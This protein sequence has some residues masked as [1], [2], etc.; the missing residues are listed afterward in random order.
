MKHK[1][2]QVHE[3]QGLPKELK[4]LHISD[5]HCK[6][7]IKWSQDLVLNNL[8]NDIER[9]YSGESRPD[10][11]FVT[12]DISFSGKKAEFD[13]AQDF[14]DRL[15]EVTLVEKDH[16]FF[17]PG[18][19]D[20]ER[21][22]EEDAIVG[23][24]ASIKNLTELDRI[25]SNPKR[26]KTLYKRQKNYRDFV[27]ANRSKKIYTDDSSIHNIT[28]ELKSI[29]IKILLLDSAWLAHDD[30]DCR[31]LAVGLQQIKNCI[32][33]NHF[34]HLV[35]ALIHHPVSWLKEFEEVLIENTLIE[36]THIVFR[37]HVHQGDISSIEKNND[38]LVIFTAGAAYESRASVNSYSFGKLNL[39]TGK[40]EKFSHSY[41]GAT[42]SWNLSGTNS[43]NLALSPVLNSEEIYSLVTSIVTEYPNY[44]SC[45]IMNL[46]ADVPRKFQDEYVL[47]NKSA[48]L[49]HRNEEI[50]DFIDQLQWLTC[51]QY[52]W[53]ATDWEAQFK[54]IVLSL[55]MS[56]I[57]ITKLT[58]ELRALDQESGMLL[59]KLL[60]T[61]SNNAIN[62]LDDSIMDF[63]STREFDSAYNLIEKWEHGVDLKNGEKR[64]LKRKKLEVALTEKS[65]KNIQLN[66]C[67]LKAL[68]DLDREE[69]LLLS[70]A[71][72]Q[73]KMYPDAETTI[74]QAF[75]LGADI[76]QARH[77]ARAIAGQTGNRQLVEK[78]M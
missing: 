15:L 74:L 64:Y 38:R 70:H 45:I 28:I 43:W 78:V 5:F 60:N 55:E 73:I 42:N 54:R 77:L 65:N 29:K 59:N 13:I 22:E 51:F 8:L 48:N 37:G 26:L 39:L 33:N 66:I 3:A 9:K 27:N 35:V 2:K 72:Y 30:T 67:D 36:D 21:S 18:N 53:E 34:E 44:I 49:D 62:S 58:D 69:L 12:G 17:V 32:D 31:N 11:I 19:H 52:I 46:K 1:K 20:I 25:Y 10:L 41:S 7:N 56:L 24:R 4:W 63:I 23:A 14:I 76:V 50:V 68:P 47:L 40:G 16:I 61:S 71:Y 75:E 6:E 57:S